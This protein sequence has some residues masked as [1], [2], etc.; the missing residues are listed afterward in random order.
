MTAHTPS[1]WNIIPEPEPY[2][3]IE[4]R[5][6]YHVVCKLWMDDAPVHDFN[7]EQRANARLISAAQSCLWYNKQ[8]PFLY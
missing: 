2:A 5:N 4:I 8:L 6:G 3:P 1:P 7:A